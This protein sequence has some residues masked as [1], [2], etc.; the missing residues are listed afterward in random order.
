MYISENK[1]KNQTDVSSP[2]VHTI[3]FFWYIWKTE[4]RILLRSSV[5][6][7]ISG[8]TKSR[9][10]FESVVYS[11]IHLRTTTVISQ[12]II[13]PCTQCYTAWQE[14]THSQFWL[15][16]AQMLLSYKGLVTGYN[17]TLSFHYAS[18]DLC[19]VFV[20]CAKRGDPWTSGSPL[21]WH[22]KFTFNTIITDSNKISL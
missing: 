5:G 16:F 18:S 12:S 14:F 17:E 11:N 6:K 7:V 2:V 19:S 20:K 13:I 10:W 15:Y 3:I 9:L 21:C 22:W 8:T 1:K 4:E